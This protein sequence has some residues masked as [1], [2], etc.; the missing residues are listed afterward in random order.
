MLCGAVTSPRRGGK[1]FD[2]HLG[3]QQRNHAA[4]RPPGDV[5]RNRVGC[6]CVTQAGGWPR[7]IQQG[8]HVYL[9]QE[10]HYFGEEI[11]ARVLS[12]E[13][14]A[15]YSALSIR[16]C[17]CT[18]FSTKG[19]RSQRGTIHQA[20]V[21]QARPSWHPLWHVIPCGMVSHRASKRQASKQ[22]SALEAETQLDRLVEDLDYIRAVRRRH[23]EEW[24]LLLRGEV[25]GFLCH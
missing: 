10:I 16:P 24:E 5:R 18:R 9:A 17:C 4:P 3:L 15:G 8:W 14:G 6:A 11:L 19:R 2:V 12:V 23:E 7:Y 25:E 13:G 21:P 22:A 1:R 20:I